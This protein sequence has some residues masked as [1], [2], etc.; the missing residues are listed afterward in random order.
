MTKLF[1][2]STLTELNLFHYNQFLH[3]ECVYRFVARG[4]TP[5]ATKMFKNLSHAEGVRPFKMKPW[6]KCP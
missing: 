4:G 3:A 5:Q 1:L 6:K 2:I